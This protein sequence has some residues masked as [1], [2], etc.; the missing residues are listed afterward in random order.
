MGK[1]NHY[2]ESHEYNYLYLKSQRV[3]QR[4]L[5]LVSK[6]ICLLN[7]FIAILYYSGVS[8]TTAASTLGKLF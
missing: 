4:F 5:R 1:L 6:M 3:E 8:T 7:F 2:R